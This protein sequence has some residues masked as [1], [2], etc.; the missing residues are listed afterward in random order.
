MFGEGGRSLSH[1]AHNVPTAP[2]PH[3]QTE[4]CLRKHYLPQTS[5]SICYAIVYILFVFLLFFLCADITTILHSSYEIPDCVRKLLWLISYFY[6]P[7]S[8][9]CSKR[10]DV[11]AVS[12]FHPFNCTT[13]SITNRSNI[14]VMVITLCLSSRLWVCHIIK[15]ASDQIGGCGSLL[16]WAVTSHDRFHFIRNVKLSSFLFGKKQLRPK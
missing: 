9:F 1:D 11:P 13:V 6:I 15:M 10:W 4:R 8:S 12:L 16:N 7:F 3:E 14:C 2:S 5:F